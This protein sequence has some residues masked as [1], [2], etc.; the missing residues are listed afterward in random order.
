MIDEILKR[1]NLKYDD[2]T[3][4]EKDTLFSWTEALN[5]NQLSVERIKTYISQ[6][7]DAVEIE[8][9]KSTLG[10]K[11]DIFLKA[12]LRNY[13]LLESFLTSPEKAKQAMERALAGIASKKA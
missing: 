6:M 12:R 8:L 3:I 9:A 7:R 1:F 11:E 5:Q 4:A 10:S 2:L 13:M